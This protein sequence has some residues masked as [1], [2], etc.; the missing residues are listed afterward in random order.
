MSDPERR[1]TPMSVRADPSPTAGDF[2]AVDA[3]L[4]SLASAFR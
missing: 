2:L 1:E 4:R 3:G